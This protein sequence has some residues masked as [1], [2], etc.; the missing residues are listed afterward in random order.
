MGVLK[1]IR[2][3]SVKMLEILVITLVAALTITVL[4]G[5]FT[6]FMTELFPF[7]GGQAEYTEELARM[8]LVWVSTFG[9]ALAFDRKVHLG[10]DFFVAKLHPDAAKLVAV[11]VQLIV[12]ALIV[13]VFIIGGFGLAMGQMSQVLTT[14][15]FLTRGMIYMSLPISG[16]FIVLFSVENIIEIHKAPVEPLNVEVGSEG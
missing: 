15:S 7:I 8:L 12:I 5:V 9:A 6:R 4:W 16:L 13:I 2:N 14:M 1:L 10:V 3:G 11:I